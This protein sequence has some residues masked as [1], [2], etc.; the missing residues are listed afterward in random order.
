MWLTVFNRLREKSGL[1]LDDLSERSGV[2]KSTLSK[3]TAGITKSPSIETIKSL[4]YACL[5]YTSDA[6]DE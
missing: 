3:I 1:S 4:V 2:P 5:L 6:A